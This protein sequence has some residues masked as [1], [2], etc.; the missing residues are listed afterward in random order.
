MKAVQ[1]FLSMEE[2]KVRYALGET[3]LRK[4]A[5]DCGAVYKIGKSMRIRLDVMD[6]YMETFLEP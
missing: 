2:A 6:S 3:T 4:L 5:K 1:R